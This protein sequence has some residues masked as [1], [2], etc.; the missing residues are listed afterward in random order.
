MSATELKGIAEFA[1]KT[2]RDALGRANELNVNSD[3]N[4][5]DKMGAKINKDYMELVEKALAMRH[6]DKKKD[7]E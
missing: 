7:D 2:E 1:V 3:I 5:T 6:G 4:F